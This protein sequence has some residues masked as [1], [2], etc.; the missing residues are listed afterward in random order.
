[1][2]LQ[3]WWRG[4]FKMSQ[5]RSEC[6]LVSPIVLPISEVANVAGCLQRCCPTCRT[7][8]DSIIKTNGNEDFSLLAI[9]PGESEFDFV[10]NPSAFDGVLREE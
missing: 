1:M 2:T 5:Q 4:G 6:L 9:F 7:M 8:K 3:R 10:P